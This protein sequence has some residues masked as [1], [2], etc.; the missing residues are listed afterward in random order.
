MRDIIKQ[1]MELDSH[2]TNSIYLN[3]IALLMEEIEL[4]KEEN[5]GLRSVIETNLRNKK[6][7]EKSIR[8]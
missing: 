6:K 5:K 7:D 2:K 4:L 8:K 3:E 1:L